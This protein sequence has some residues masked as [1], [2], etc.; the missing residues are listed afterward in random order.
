[1]DTSV[2]TVH[3]YWAN[4]LLFVSCYYVHFMAFVQ[5]CVVDICMSVCLLSVVVYSLWLSGSFPI[6]HIQTPSL[7][8]IGTTNSKKSL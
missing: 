8:S 3:N 1:M 2:I 7:V 4:H 6:L 5:C